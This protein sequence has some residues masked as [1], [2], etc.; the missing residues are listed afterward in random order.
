MLAMVYSGIKGDSQTDFSNIRPNA[1]LSLQEVYKRG[2]L[3]QAL[4]R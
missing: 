2:I 3:L 4:R 1:D